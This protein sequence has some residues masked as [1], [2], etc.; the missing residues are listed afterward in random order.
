M[1]FRRGCAVFTLFVF[2]VVTMF[3]ASS[4]TVHTSLIAHKRYLYRDEWG[5]FV[6]VNGTELASM[7]AGLS[8][9]PS[10][11]MRIYCTRLAKR[12]GTVVL[13]EADR[14]APG[15]SWM[16]VQNLLEDQGI[17]SCSYD[18]SGLG[19]S[20][21]AQVAPRTNDQ[22]AREF[23]EA[24]DQRGV[25]P[26]F[27]VVGHGAGGDISLV[28]AHKYAAEVVAL[29]LIDSYGPLADS[30]LAELNGDSM[31]TVQQQR[32]SQLSLFDLTRAVDPLGLLFGFDDNPADFEP[33]S[34]QDA[35]VATF[36]TNR[37]FQAQYGEYLA[38]IDQ[39]I[40]P[41]KFVN[42]VPSWHR[43]LL[44]MVASQSYNARCEDMGYSANS[45][46][47]TD[48]LER[49]EAAQNI[50]QVWRD[51]GWKNNTDFTLCKF[52]CEPNLIWTHAPLVA[53]HI[54]ALLK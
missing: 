26:P 37:N 1:R 54:R 45:Q 25:E 47:C 8:R 50:T 6:T 3:M 9:P 34:L 15:L 10:W 5:E 20:E 16:A 46:E 49:N 19:F 14:G 53:T 27:A 13:L 40:P 22:L 36:S 44:V 21:T 33:A 4:L 32:K 30:V 42:T 2:V 17:A 48:L 52:P 11:K 29:G 43:P 24:L 41:S 35:F 12:N 7:P 39:G 18:R 23:R 31:T 51:M 38:G 28:F